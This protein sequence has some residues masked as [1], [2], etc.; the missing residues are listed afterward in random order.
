MK[1]KKNSGGK[2]ARP[3]TKHTFNNLLAD[4][5]L[6]VYCTCFYPLFQNNSIRF[7]FFNKVFFFLYCCLFFSG[8]WIN[9]TEVD[10]ALSLFTAGTK[11]WP[12]NIQHKCFNFIEN[13]LFSS[14]V[15]AVMGQAGLAHTFSLTWCWIAW[16]KVSLSHTHF[17]SC[18]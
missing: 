15:I 6:C 17:I 14:L 13:S 11:K 3:H 12:I 2:F 9:A 8:R 5:T 4:F 16:L 7:I 18:L 10:P 1:K